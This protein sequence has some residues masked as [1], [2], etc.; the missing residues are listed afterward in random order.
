MKANEANSSWG[1]RF[2]TA[3]DDLM[4]DY[5]ESQ[6]FDRKLYDRDIDASIAH[7]KMLGRQNVIA[8][9]EADLIVSGLEKI[10][11]E[12]ASGQFVWKKELEDVH[13]NIESRLTELV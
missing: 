10:R 9:E 11:K 1:G 3:P 2:K 13:M 6:S 4:T 7:A 12:I 8:K 5:S